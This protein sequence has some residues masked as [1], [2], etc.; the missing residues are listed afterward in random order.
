MKKTYVLLCLIQA[1]LELSENV[2]GFEGRPAPG[3]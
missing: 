1:H 2:L 3:K